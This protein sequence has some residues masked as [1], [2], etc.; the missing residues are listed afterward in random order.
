[1]SPLKRLSSA[2]VPSD[3]SALWARVAELIADLEFW[4]AIVKLRDLK[5]VRAAEINGVKEHYFENH[6]GWAQAVLRK[7]VIPALERKQD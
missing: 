2:G 7:I 4:Q 6:V 3:E 1:M 5:V